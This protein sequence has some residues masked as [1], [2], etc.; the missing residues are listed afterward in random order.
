MTGVDRAFKLDT[1]RSLG[2]DHVI[3]YRP[4][5]FTR[6]GQRYDLILDTKTHRSPFRYLAHSIPAAGT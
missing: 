4:D 1:L 5:D 2:F 6:N 3:D